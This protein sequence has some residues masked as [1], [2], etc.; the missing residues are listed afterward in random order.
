MVLHSG[1]PTG[2][3]SDEDL[4]LISVIIALVACLV[5][6]AIIFTLVFICKKRR[7]RVAKSIYTLSRPGHYYI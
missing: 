1:S 6:V 2:T 3:S 5:T 4:T 7:D